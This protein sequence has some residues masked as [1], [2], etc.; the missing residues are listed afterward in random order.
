MLQTV[1]F[2]RLTS[3][4][5]WYMLFQ[6]QTIMIDSEYAKHA[7]KSN[8]ASAENSPYLLLSS[9]WFGY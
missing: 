4:S 8:T 2:Q 1:T 5:S 6:Q 9:A 7:S 3:L